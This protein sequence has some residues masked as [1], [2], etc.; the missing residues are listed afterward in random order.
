MSAPSLKLQLERLLIPE[1]YESDPHTLE[2]SPNEWEAWFQRQQQKV[3]WRLKAQQDNS[4][5]KV[6]W[7]QRWECDHPGSPRDRRKPDLSPRNRRTRNGSIKV[8]CK[9]RLHAS[10]AVDSD[11]VT[12]VY[13]WRHTGHDSVDPT[14]L[15]NMRGSR[16]PNVVRA[17]LDDKVHNGFDQKAI[18]AFIRMSPEELAQ[19]TPD[20]DVVPCSIKISPMDIYN[21]VRHKIDIDTRLA[22]Q[23]NESIEEWLKKLNEVGWS[24]LYEPT[25]GEEIRNGFTL[26]LCSPGN[27]STVL[28]RNQVTG[29][30]V[31]LAFM[32]TNHESHF[33]LEHFLKW[34][35]KCQ[36]APKT[37]MIDCSDTEA[38]AIRKACPD[39]VVHILY[40]YWHLWQAWDSNIK[41]K[42][43]F[44]YMRCKED[45]AELI[46][47]V[48]KA[49][50]VLLKAKSAEEFDYQWEWIEC[51]YDDQCAWLKYMREEW[52]PKKE[53]WAGAWRKHAHHGVDTN[54]FIESWHSNLKKNYIG[55]GRRQRI[56]Y[57]I[58]ILSQDVV[59][60][61]MR[62]HV[63]SGLGFR[64]RHL[65]EAEMKA[66]KLADELP[67]ADASTR[68][69]ELESESTDTMVQVESFTQ[70]DIYY[71]IT[72]EEEKITSCTCSAY[73]ESLLTCKHIFLALRFTNYAIFLP[74]VIIPKRRAVEI[75]DDEEVEHQRAHKRR[76]VVKIRN[77]IAKL[78]KVDYWVR[79]ENDDMLDTM[80]RESL[81]RL[82]STVDG[83]C[84]LSRDTMFSIPDNA[85]Q[86]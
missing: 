64:G 17:W 11:K 52:I 40:C 76:L 9:A 13:H 2:L 26:A 1:T 78:D 21:A 30:D 44:K 86:W 74:H 34:L 62:A 3:T 45:C 35:R 23:L 46:K 72:I 4:R 12:V 25:P 60:D 32:L 50:A 20:A 63:R 38:L 15:D 68:V 36:F 55:R 54:N 41:E 29:R 28:A 5:S 85:T 16:N 37:I 59:P 77:G 67:Y 81:T 61:Y 43:V 6:L 75:D 10:Q 66:K 56:D 31:P 18:K 79:A 82:L 69:I 83:L 42:L 51:E 8:G 47:D 48:R 65:C 70:D 27:K 80:S 39:V 22:P 24:T 58:H 33:L 71:T 57:I 84:H 14:S 7:T 19:I 53:R 73:T 49:V